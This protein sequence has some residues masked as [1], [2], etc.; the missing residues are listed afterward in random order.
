MLFNAGIIFTQCDVRTL[1]AAIAVLTRM[2]ALG[3]T[4]QTRPGVPIPLL[5]SGQVSV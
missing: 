2:H 4:T 5:G 1:S 3:P